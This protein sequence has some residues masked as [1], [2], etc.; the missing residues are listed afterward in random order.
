MQRTSFHSLQP[1]L[2]SGFLSQSVH[3]STEFLPMNSFKSF[4]PASDLIT[5]LSKID[6]AMVGNVTLEGIS[7]FL[8][9]VEHIVMFLAAL[10]TVLYSKWQDHNMTQ[11]VIK[12]SKVAYTH[13]QIAGKFFITT[14]VWLLTVAYPEARKMTVNGYTV[15][16]ET[17][18]VLSDI[19]TL[20]T[21]R[22]FTIL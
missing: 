7:E 4:P 18:S 13:L 9:I 11:R 8:A 21:S 6:W 3:N 14:G 15:A 2:A 20:A 22:Q 5:I 19:Y 17:Y 16:R 12:G 1:R 10:A